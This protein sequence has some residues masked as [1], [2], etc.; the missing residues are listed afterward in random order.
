MKQLKNLLV[1]FGFAF[2]FKNL[3][4]IKR[5]FVYAVEIAFQSKRMSQMFDK[6]KTIN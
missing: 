6:V 2:N 4:L 1:R 5:P 3:K